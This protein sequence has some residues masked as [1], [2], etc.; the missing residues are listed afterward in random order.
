MSP[1]KKILQ[2]LKSPKPFEGKKLYIKKCKKN[3]L[4]RTVIKE[5][6][7]DSSGSF[8]I[9]LPAGTYCIVEEYKTIK[10]QGVPPSGPKNKCL[11]KQWSCCD[12]LLKLPEEK[13]QIININYHHYCEGQSPCEKQNGEFTPRE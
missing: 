1:D 12:Y 3:S 10:L 11:E 4:R 8:Y 5:V 6:T 2:E 7:A 9:S 13:N